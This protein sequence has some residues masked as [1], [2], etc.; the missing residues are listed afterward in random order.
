MVIREDIVVTNSD[1]SKSVKFGEPMNIPRDNKTLCKR[2]MKSKKNASHEYVEQFCKFFVDI[3]FKG[4]D[5]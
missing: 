2:V 3:D 4:D 5:H 1:G